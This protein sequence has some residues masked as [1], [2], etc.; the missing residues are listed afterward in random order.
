M[1]VADGLYCGFYDKSTRTFNRCKFDC[2]TQIDTC[3]LY[4]VS[5]NRKFDD[6][7][8][9]REVR[10]RETDYKLLRYSAC[11]LATDETEN[12]K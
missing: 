9:I 4:G 12:T 6:D 10:A 7:M 11:L 3:A 2:I 8:T 1:I 5:R